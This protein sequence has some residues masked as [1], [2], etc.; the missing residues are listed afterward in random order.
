MLEIFVCCLFYAGFLLGLLSR[1]TYSSKTSPDFQKMTWCYIPEA[2]ALHN[3][4]CINLKPHISK[5]SLQHPDY[6]FV[7]STSN[8]NPVGPT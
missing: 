4:C 1:A 2:T 5:I 6:S 8:L 3:H 7:S